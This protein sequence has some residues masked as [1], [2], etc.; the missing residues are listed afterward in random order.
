MSDLAAVRV[1]VC[2]QGGCAIADVTGW[3]MF[4]KVPVQCSACTRS[5]QNS[6]GHWRCTA[7]HDFDLCRECFHKIGTP[8]SL[9]A[10]SAKHPTCKCP[11]G[12]C[13]MADVSGW[14][15]FSR[16]VVFCGLCGAAFKN[17]ACESRVS[18]D[19]PIHLTCT[20]GHDYDLCGQCAQK[21]GGGMQWCNRGVL[22]KALPPPLWNE[23]FGSEELPTFSPFRD[24]M[25][26]VQPEERPAPSIWA[27]F[28][29]CFA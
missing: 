9:L 6:G 19:M 13:A 14:A 1:C 16:G 17:T 20:G 21:A 10:R 18:S 28:F 25:P 5:F 24:V 4:S 22:S 2:S 26:H 8:P 29:R 11:F 3:S 7:G 23:E 15:L 27:S 12:R